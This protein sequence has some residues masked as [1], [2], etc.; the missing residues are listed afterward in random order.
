MQLYQ[1][2]HGNF[3]HTLVEVCGAVFNDLDGHDFLRLEV[4]AL[5]DLAESTLTQHVEDEVAVS[6]SISG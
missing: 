6:R 2:Q 3:H 4:L 5:D 1:V